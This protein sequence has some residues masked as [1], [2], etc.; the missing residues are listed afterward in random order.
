M[1]HRQFEAR[2][3]AYDTAISVLEN[4]DV[5][6]GDP[7]GIEQMKQAKVLAASLEKQCTRFVMRTRVTHPS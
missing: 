2:L 6:P 5:D 4:F 1:T 3:V 7:D